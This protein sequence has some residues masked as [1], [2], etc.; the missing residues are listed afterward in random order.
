MYMFYKSKIILKLY[1]IVNMPMICQ[2][3]ANNLSV[4]SKANILINIKYLLYNSKNN[5]LLIC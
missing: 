2:K 4:Y 1:K 3:V 5:Q